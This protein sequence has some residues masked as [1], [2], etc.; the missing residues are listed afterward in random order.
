MKDQ[1][2]QGHPLVHRK[3]KASPDYMKVGTHT[4]TTTADTKSNPCEFYNKYKEHKTKGDFK[5]FSLTG[6]MQNK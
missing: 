4:H 3:L 1:A 6:K 2:F 5:V